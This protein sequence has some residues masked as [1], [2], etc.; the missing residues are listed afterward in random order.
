MKMAISGIESSGKSRYMM[1]I[2]SKIV[3]RNAKWYKK[4]GIE[5]PI[6]VNFPLAADFV[7]WIQSHDG[8]SVLYWENIDDLIQHENCDIFIDELGNYFDSRNWENLSLN[9]RKW[10]TQGAKRGI[11]IYGA[12]QDFAQVDKA[13]RRLVNHL[14]HVKKLVG[15]RRPSATTPPVRVIWGVCLIVELDPAVYKE[16]K[17][18]FAM[19]SALSLRFFTIQRRYCEAYDTTAKIKISAPPK[20]KHIARECE[21]LKCGFHRVQHI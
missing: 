8:V 5:R 7:K 11:E 17:D 15:S 6:L 1:M 14:I 20:L 19:K 13:F 4:T 9:S 21:D 3:R 18:K 10:L 2:L 16:D 12:C